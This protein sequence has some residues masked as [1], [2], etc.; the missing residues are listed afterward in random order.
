LLPAALIALAAACALLLQQPGAAGASAPALT[1][2][3]VDCNGQVTPVDS[4]A[5][6]RADAGLPV[7]KADPSCPDIGTPLTPDAARLPAG[8][9]LTW[10]NVDCLSGVVPVDSL[11]ILLSDAGSPIAQGPGCLHIGG[12]LDGDGIPPG[13][14]LCPDEPEDFDGF[15]DGDGCPDN[16]WE[17]LVAHWAPVIYQDTDDTDPAAD[18]VTNFDFDGNWDG[19]DNWQNQPI[20]PLNAYTYYWV[21]ETATNW[22][23]GYAMFHPQDWSEFCL[24]LVCHEND[25]EGV[26]LTI[27]RDGSQFGQFLLMSTLAHDVVYTYQDFDQ[28]PSAAAT[29]FFD[30]DVQFSGSHPLVYIE[31]K[32]HGI[33]GADRWEAFGFPGGDGIV[34]V[35]GNDAQ[36]PVSGNQSGVSYDLADIQDV[37]ARRCDPTTFGSYG[38][39]AGDDWTIDAA[40]APWGWGGWGYAAPVFFLAPATGIGDS[41]GGLG[42]FSRWDDFIDNDG[43][44]LVDEADEGYVGS[45]FMPGPAEYGGC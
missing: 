13:Q 27:R 10:G 28:F 19:L 36:Q 38:A 14:D 43:D 41:F 1:W 29:G 25:L 2:G 7:A 34:Y 11:K 26:L 4:L 44:T 6:L 39:F 21:V 16:E 17:A 15:E 32:G 3:D 20:Y 42:A 40:H 5:I 37:W 22:F 35:Y 24:P 8:L 30:G 9:Q 45:S 23:I 33:T 31:A 12:R 18:F